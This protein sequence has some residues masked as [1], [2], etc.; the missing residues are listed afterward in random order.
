MFKM[1]QRWC[2]FLHRYNKS[3]K[4]KICVGG[5]IGSGKSTQL[6][7]CAKKHAV[8]PEPAD[9]HWKEGLTK[10][11]A[12][13]SRYFTSFQI[14]VN[15]W[16]DQQ[17]PSMIQKHDASTIIIERSCFEGEHVFSSVGL[18]N[19]IID[20]YQFEL[21]YPSEKK[22]WIPDVYIYIQTSVDECFKR[23]NIRGRASESMIG[24]QYLRELEEAHATLVKYLKSKCIQI[25]IINGNQSVEEVNTEIKSI[26]SKYSD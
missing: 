15:Q 9:T 11:Y 6:K 7:L 25:Y 5:N 12:N 14:Q 23:I 1:I 10:L 3:N 19:G 26:L 21:L 22:P 20:K 8:I 16:F 17:V 13:P 24:I 4:I 18:D 2:Q